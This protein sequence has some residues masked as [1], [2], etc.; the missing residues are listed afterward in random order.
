M[1]ADKSNLEDTSVVS[2]ASNVTSGNKREGYR[3]K[4]RKEKKKKKKK[5]VDNKKVKWKNQIKTLS[6]PTHL[7]S[8]PKSNL[9]IKRVP[10]AIASE[11]QA[12]V[13]RPQVRGIE[14]IDDLVY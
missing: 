7:L 14:Q 2:D 12:Y 1:C 4:P 8:S 6:F 10:T 3:S 11:P 9:R 5:L 13:D